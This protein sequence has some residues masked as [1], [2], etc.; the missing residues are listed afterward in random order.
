MARKP[1]RS[2][3]RSKSGTAAPPL[4]GTDR[5]KAV[6]A[7][8]AL[9]AQHPFE[10]IGLAEVA[11]RAGLSLSQLRAEFGSAM[12]ILG[13][14][15]KD[16]DRKVL[17]AESDELEDAPARERLFDVLMRRIEALAPYKDAIRSLVNSTRRNP[18]LAMALN[19]M[20]MRSQRW[21][22]TSAGID[23]HG[24]RG[25]LRIQG[26]ALLFGRVVTIWTEDDDESLDRTMAVLDRGLASA[27]RWSGLM[28]D[29]FCIPAMLCRGVSRRR[30]RRPLDDGPAE[31]EA[32]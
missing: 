29:L 3:R 2:T 25:L 28:D 7:L 8:M 27:E 20:A 31:A 6:G 15:T 32:A 14:F 13:A 18:G 4:S 11:G 22:L 9:L 12:A 17:D 16:I 30:R 19:G 21:M 23:T 10:E 26:T 1:T 5:E 24:P